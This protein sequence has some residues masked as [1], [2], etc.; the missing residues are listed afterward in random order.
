[1]CPTELKRVAEHDANNLNLGYHTA[2]T[3]LDIQEAL[4]RV[5]HNSLNLRSLHQ[6]DA[7][8]LLWLHNLSQSRETSFRTRPIA[9]DVPQGSTLSLLLFELFTT[10]MP[11][12][13]QVMAAFY[14]DGIALVN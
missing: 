8:V 2:T 13:Q 1:M 12:Y 6:G 3:F 7:I 14:V 5:W 11:S 9:S 4:D 10:D